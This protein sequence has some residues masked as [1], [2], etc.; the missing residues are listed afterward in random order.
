MNAEAAALKFVSSNRRVREDR[1]FVVGHGRYVAD[2]VLDQ[3]LHVAI[4]PS[5]HPAARIISIDASETLKMPGVVYALTGEQL[6]K[7]VDPL[8]NGLDTPKVRRYPLA[9]GQVRYAGEWVV[10]VVAETR[11]QAEDAIEKIR[12]EYEPL[13]FV[14]DA[15]EAI[16]DA[17]PKVHPEHGTNVLLD[18]T[19]VWGEVDKHFAESSRHLKFRV[20]WGRN[21]TVPIETFGVVA[22]WDP[23]REMLDVW[24]SI[25]MPKY[26]DQIARALR[27]PANNVRVHHDVDVGGS[28]GVKRGIKHSVLASHLS[29]IL[30]RPVRLIEDRLE[31]M[32]AGDAHGPERIFDVEVAFNDNGIVKS[33]KMQA[34]D[35]VG[36]YAGRS[37]FQLGKPI[38]AIVGPYKIESVQ[39][40]AIA[41]LSNKAAQEAVRGFGQAPTNYA[42][43][44]AIDKVAAAVGLDRIE[45]RRRNFIR[46]DEFPYLIPSGTHYDSGDYHTVV[47]KVL[48]SADYEALLKERDELRASGMMAGIGIAACLEPSGGNSS[49]E[50]LLNEKNTTTT[51]MD[52]C[53]INVDGVGFVTVTIH[54]TSA[55]Q[56][57]ET[58]AATVVGEVLEIDP[59]LI[60]IVRPDSLSSLPS[61]T[62]VGSRMAIMMGG[63][64][65]Y[66][67]Q[68]LKSKL[69]KI[70]AHQ[71]GIA[72]DAA[73]YSQG[74]VA[75]PKSN[76]TLSWTD[77]VNIGHRHFHALPDGMEPGLETT[78]V[79]QVP[80]GTKLPE[81]GRVQ[82]YPC[83]S[84]EFHLVLLA[85]DPQIAKSEIRRYVI[86]HDCG[87]VINPHIVKGM[88]L[89]GIAHGIGAALLEEFVYDAEGQILTQ[90]FMDYLL[91]SSH[92][93]PNVEIVHHCTPSPFTVFGQKGSGESGYLGSPAAISGAINDAVSPLGISFSK[94]P[95]RIAVISDAVA[96]AQDAKKKDQ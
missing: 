75:D 84:F 36:G 33:M 25:Q 10:A 35:N 49:F 81:N 61:N 41:T 17:S 1:R 88:T 95:I 28:Y 80:T 16:T 14:I 6:V 85:F 42:I 34:L 63:A 76:K 9:V 52:S 56:G 50:P 55:G 15:E 44:T 2:I 70:G 92:E 93:I 66:A 7:A 54:T 20:A 26:P 13:P 12:I 78:H 72:E 90:S 69:T 87:T 30:G 45:V 71:F 29:R 67:A 43:E 79:M 73:V 68:K 94:L 83:H 89:G 60:R 31:N 32:R 40:R 24:A 27:I 91:P 86:G 74:S 18:K 3:M 39:Y 53:R 64:C 11:A 58:L 62:P 46:S 5:Q 37:P 59:D 51:W 47:N 8:M 4:L 57:H 22:R 77:L 23:W 21:S 48:A 19:F 38:G 82:M 65:Y 96:A